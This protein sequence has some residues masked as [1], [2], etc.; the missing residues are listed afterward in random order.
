MPHSLS[1]KKRARQTPRR[2]ERNRTTKSRL[3]TA[4]RAILKAIEARDLT[5]A[6][7]HLRRYE[8]LLHRTAAR[9]PIHR[10]TAARLIRRVESRLADLEKAAG[11]TA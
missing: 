1:A 10:N 8:Q 5:A 7:R 9:G 6:R 2:R 11:S 4:R 3:R